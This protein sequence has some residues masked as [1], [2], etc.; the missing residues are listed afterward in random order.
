MESVKNKSIAI[1]PHFYQL[2]TPA[3]PAFLSLGEVGMII[4]GGTGPT[5]KIITSQIEALGID[6]GRIEYIILTHTHADHIGALPHLKRKWPHIKLVASA[7]GSKILSTRELYHEFLLVDLGITQLMKAKA[8]CD[9]VPAIPEDYSFEVDLIVKGGDTIELGDGVSWEIIDTPGHSP[10]HICLYEKKEATLALGD[11]VGFY[12]PE[13]DV[14]WPNYFVSLPG[15]CDSIRKLSH[16]PAKRAALSHNAVIEGDV[17]KFLEKALKA[18]E[19]YHND[20]MQRLGRGESV[21]SIALDKAQFVSSLTDIQPY[22]V[23]Y[24]LCKFMINRS[25]KVGAEMS[26]SLS[27]EEPPAP[28]PET[29]EQPKEPEIEPRENGFIG[30]PR[31]KKALSLNERSSL[32]ALL[33]E[34]MR[35][36]LQEAP[37]AADLFSGLWKLVD[38]TAKGA[39]VNRLRF[40]DSQ[41]GFQMFEIKAETGEHLGHLNMLYLKKPIPCYYL[42][43]VEVAASFRRKGLGN[44]ILKYFADFL[45]SKSAIGILDNIIPLEEPT[46]DIYLKHSWKPIEEI[47]GHLML[48]RDDNYMIF[49]PPAL[50]GKHLKQPV[51]KLMYHLKRHR[52]VIDIRDNE[53]MVKRTMSEFR[54]LYQALLAYFGTELNNPQSSVFMR[55]LFTRFVTKFISFRHRIGDLLGYTGGESTEQITLDNGIEKLQ[56][57]SHAPREFVKQKALGDGDLE[58]L[59]RLPEDLKKEPARV[60]DSLPNYRRPSFMAWLKKHGRAFK[61]S[62]TLGD[63]MDLGFDPTRLKEITIDDKEYIF[64]RIQAKRI[65][66]LKKRNAFLEQISSKMSNTKVKN[67]WL[68]TNPILLIIQDRGNGYALRPKIDAIHMEEALEQLQ[69]DPKLKTLNETTRIDRILVDTVKAATGDISNQLDVEKEWVLDQLTPFVSWDLKNNQPKM[70]IEFNASYLESLWMM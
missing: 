1:T 39:K 45:I 33:D 29:A 54:N 11:A 27:K 25:G 21:E 12:V 47:V 43:Y 9:E 5:F 62:L 49:I 15:Y 37:L 70:V 48:Y 3:F 24:D 20:L 28:G 68:K 18:T 35:L 30:L 14:F 8:E 38:A 51:S 65:E 32:L 19:N 69:S 66:E 4:E 53:T 42:V 41:D 52:A 17:K 10:C 2:G 64:E 63:L 31:K 59:S 44:R 23:I 57:K 55:F 7:A 22:K 13:K 58:L 56:I 6:P 46:Y 50:E 67:A 36:G 61:D 16:L 40:N 26:F 60:I 34:G